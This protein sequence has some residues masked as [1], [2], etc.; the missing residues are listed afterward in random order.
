MLYLTQEQNVTCTRHHRDV[1]VN[2]GM[3]IYPELFSKNLPQFQ[4]CFPETSLEFLN[5][6]IQD[7]F[8]V[9][10]LEICAS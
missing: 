4:D 1:S 5:E 9:I 7:T 6:Y 2:G 3:L 8:Y 10:S